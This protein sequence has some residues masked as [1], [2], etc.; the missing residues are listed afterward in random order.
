MTINTRN[1]S[2]LQYKG[3]ISP[4]MIKKSGEVNLD[5]ATQPHRHNYYMLLWSFNKAGRHVVDSHIYSIFPKTIWFIAPGEVHCIEP[6]QPQGVM[7]QFIPEF[8][9]LKSITG[10][11]LERLDLFHSHGHP[12][13]LSD[14]GVAALMPHLIAMTDAF[15]SLSPFRMDIIEAHLKLFLIECN[16]RMRLTVP[17]KN[18]GKNQHPAVLVFKDMVGIH[19][20]EWHKIDEYADAMCLSSHYLSEIFR[21]ATG[22][23]PKN[24]LS[25][26]IIAEA[27]RMVLFSDLSFKEI[28]Y[29]LGFDDS[30]HFSRFFKQQ[31]GLSFQDFKM[32][33]VK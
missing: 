18:E 33:I 7:I 15:L 1:E 3:S 4:F 23:S 24:Y 31:T 16:S 17:Q 9:P 32:S 20:R 2:M 30:S 12:L 5:I 11:F 14:G 8:F 13:V 25:S 10:E 27:K 19:F 29:H 22:Q 26:Q 6:P 21:E 28:G